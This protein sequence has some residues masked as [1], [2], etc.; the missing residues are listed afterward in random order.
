VDSNCNN[1]DRKTHME[2]SGTACVGGGKG[3]WLLGNGFSEMGY[4]LLGTVIGL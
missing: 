2:P 1:H 4:L 3:K